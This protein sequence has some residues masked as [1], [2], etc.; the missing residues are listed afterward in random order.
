M[1]KL[2]LILLVAGLQLP[3]TTS[4]AAG[5]RPLSP[6]DASDQARRQRLRA[7][8]A[9]GAGAFA[10][11]ADVGDE[12]WIMAAPATSTAITLA[13]TAVPAASEV[14]VEITELIARIRYALSRY[15]LAEVEAL[16]TQI[17][18]EF[19]PYVLEL[20]STDLVPLQFALTRKQDRNDFIIRQRALCLLSRALSTP[21]NPADPAYA[22]IVWLCTKAPLW[23]VIRTCELLREI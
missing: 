4:N 20:H 6:D 16:F 5:K 2:L 22:P 9:A 21:L 19:P 1:K 3:T 12:S 15:S 11:G 7:A 8:A 10:A 18:N 13:P 14:P 23:V 17:H